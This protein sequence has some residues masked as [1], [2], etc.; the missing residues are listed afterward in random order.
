[1]SVVADVLP[2]ADHHDGA[3]GP[4]DGSQDGGFETRQDGG[5]DGSYE[6]RSNDG[7][8]PPRTPLLF[9]LAAGSWL[10]ALPLGLLKSVSG[11]SRF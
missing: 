1:M 9:A 3:D 10:V 11:G 7:G 8:E 6:A 4:H 5:H 2:E